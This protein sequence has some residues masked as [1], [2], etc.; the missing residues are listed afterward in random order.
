METIT[1][2]MEENQD[3]EENV[4]KA[5]QRRVNLKKET[6]PKG[7]KEKKNKYYKIIF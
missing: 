7:E 6:I 4:K 3:D 2:I 5:G 1:Q